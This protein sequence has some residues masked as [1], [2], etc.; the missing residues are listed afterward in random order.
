MKIK[1][2]VL[3]PCGLYKWEKI[4]SEQEKEEMYLTYPPGSVFMAFDSEET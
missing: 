3:L 2:L 4:N 1:Y